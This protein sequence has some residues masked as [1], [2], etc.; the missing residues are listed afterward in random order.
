MELKDIKV[1]KLNVEKLNETINT[2]FKSKEEVE[3]RAFSYQV[4]EHSLCIAT[5]NK[6][7]VAIFD[8]E[9]CGWLVEEQVKFD[10]IRA[11]EEG[12]RDMFPTKLVGFSMEE[13]QDFIDEEVTLEDFMGSRF[14]Y[15]SRIKSN[16]REFVN[17]MT[18]E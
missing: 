5:S 1:A 16:Q 2:Y 10:V 4:S 11:F 12:G 8:N 14:N 7:T 15:N 13:M 9:L 17:F 18:K 6:G 3:E